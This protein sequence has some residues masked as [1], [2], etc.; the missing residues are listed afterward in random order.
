MLLEP[1]PKVIHKQRLPN[2]V[3]DTILNLPKFSKILKLGIDPKDGDV[4]IWYMFV[5]CN[6]NAL[7]QRKFVR[8]GTGWDIKENL[9][10]I[11]T[12]FQGP[13]VWHYFEDKTFE[14]NPW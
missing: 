6:E 12:V 8:V 14:N 1:L 4:Y 5:Q 9:E 7:E 3:E 13:F 2:P 11:S 10:Y